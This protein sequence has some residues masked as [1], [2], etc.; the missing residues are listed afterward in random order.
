MA[1]CNT[2]VRTIVMVALI[3]VLWMI[4]PASAAEKDAS[5]PVIVT[6]ILIDKRPDVLLVRPD[7]REPIRVAVPK[8]LDKVLVER[9]KTIFNV[10]RVRVACKVEGETNKLVGIEQIATQRAGVFIGEVVEVHE[11]FWVE[12]KPKNGPAEGFA[13]AV[14]PDKPHPVIDTLKRLKKGDTVAIRYTTD[15]ER[16]RIQQI[17][18]KGE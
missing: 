14:P 11:N 8:D 5:K 17:Q 18:I 1:R 9:M 13:A 4:D 16:H 7:G 10:N 2:L 3:G 15:Y 6:G 12:V